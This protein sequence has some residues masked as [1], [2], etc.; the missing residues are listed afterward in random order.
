MVSR[1][2][3]ESPR[4]SRLILAS[5]KAT[6]TASTSAAASYSGGKCAQSLDRIDAPGYVF[7][8]LHYAGVDRTTKSLLMSM[9]HGLFNSSIDCEVNRDTE[10]RTTLSSLLSL[11]VSLLI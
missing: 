10:F 11:A 2:K 3:A 8:R 1:A 9:S 4:V 7:R 6:R 5:S